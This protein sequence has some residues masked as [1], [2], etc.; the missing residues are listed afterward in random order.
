MEKKLEEQCVKCKHIQ[1][2]H[3]VV[4]GHE[5]H[6]EKCGGKVETTPAT[7]KIL[8]PDEIWGIKQATNKKEK[9]L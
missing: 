3:C 8:F 4:D 9:N 2:Y 6:C 5:Q 1:P 7:L